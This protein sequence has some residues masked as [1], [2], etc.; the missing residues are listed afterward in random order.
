M[1][2]SHDPT[3]NLNACPADPG[4]RLAAAALQD[5]KCG[6]RKGVRCEAARKNLDG[7][8]SHAQPQTGRAT[9]C[10]TCAVLHFYPLRPRSITPSDRCDSMVRGCRSGSWLAGLRRLL[11]P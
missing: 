3:H 8:R 11:A 6:G 5:D 1:D 2:K 4:E 10:F 7:V 9:H